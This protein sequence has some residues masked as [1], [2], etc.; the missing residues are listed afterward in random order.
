MVLHVTGIIRIES[1]IRIEIIRVIGAEFKM[2]PSWILFVF[3]IPGM[4]SLRYLSFVRF[5]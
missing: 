5:W 1:I 3:A 4:T 2:A